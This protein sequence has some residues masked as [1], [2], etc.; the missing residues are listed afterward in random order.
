MY[1]LYTRVKKGYICYLCDFHYLHREV[2]SERHSN[3]PGLKSQ[4]IQCD[5]EFVPSLR[6]PGYESRD[7]INLI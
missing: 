2:V 1:K 6:M 7:T 5:L 4:R 3:S